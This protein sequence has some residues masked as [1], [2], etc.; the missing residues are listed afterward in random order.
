MIKILKLYI[1]RVVLNTSTNKLFP[2][3]VSMS[4]SPLFRDCSCGNTLKKYKSKTR[5][6]AT[7][8]V[9]ECKAHV[10]QLYCKICKNIYFPEEL[11]LIAPEKSYFG[12]DVIVYIGTEL[13]INYRNDEEILK[14]LR[15]KNIKISLRE[16][17]YLGKKF[18]VYLALAHRACQDKI[19]NYME[20]KGGYILHL[21]GTCEGDSPHLFSFI[22]EL[23]GV[24]LENIKIPSENIKQIKP[25]LEGI[26][27]LYGNPIAIVHDMSAAIIRAVESVF[28][29]VKDLICHFHF[30]RDIGKDLFST[31][32]SCILR[33]LKIFKTRTAL[34]KIAMEFKIYIDHDE[35]LKN[36]LK[37]SMKKYFFENDYDSLMP[38]V[39][40]YLLVTW[41][42][43][44][45]N[46]SH[47]YGFPFD[48]PHVDFC[49]RLQ[50][51]YPIMKNLKKKM[52]VGSPRLS[53]VKL[54][55]TM[56]DTS[57][58]NTLKLIKNKI[59]I[60]DELRDAMQIA[61]TNGDRGLNDN[62]SDVEIKTIEAG[63]KN[64]R[65]LEKIINLSNTD[66]RFKKMVN[67]IDKYWGKLFSDPIEIKT[68][69]GVLVIQPQRTNN[70]LEQF[71][72][73]IKSGNRKKMGTSSLSKMLKAMIANTPLVKNLSIP[74][75]V[76]II[77]DGKKDL[78]ERFSEIDISSVRATLRQEDEAAR[79]YPKGMGRIFKMPDLP[80]KISQ[81]DLKMNKLS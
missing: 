81:I 7:L 59:S 54:S 36:C 13:F 65:Q 17:A 23:S 71:F 43:E 74:E 67:Q 69:N 49:D 42:L 70:M 53:L 39:A 48:R 76:D 72:R 27:K 5:R 38:P 11:K 40:I 30:L 66:I 18:I 3:T 21:D 56:N 34:R 26:K 6:I 28:P 58:I 62:G 9:G 24:V 73:G 25:P 35:E 50:K 63:V 32:Y 22:D 77:L 15:E 46:K 20:K 68:D 10:T 16:V 60:F 45:K 52:P 80:N 41:V 19:K 75:Y 31:E 29:N 8:L 1:D 4:F 12:F 55:R 47:G 44:S 14:S 79:K 64:F 57:L 78:A 2:N 51:S 61:S 37:N 33:F